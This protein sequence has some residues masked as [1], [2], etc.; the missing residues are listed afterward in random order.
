MKMN[1]KKWIGVLSIGAI[2]GGFVSAGIPITAEAVINAYTVKVKDEIYKYDKQELINDFLNFK[3]GDKSILYDDFA[4]KLKEGHGFY[5]F[6]DTEKGFV[7]Y[8]DISNA[9][10][11]TKE[12]NKSFDV[13]EFI[14]SKETKVIEVS[15]VKKAIVTKEGEVK[16]ETPLNDD[17]NHKENENKDKQDDDKSEDV[18]NKDSQSSEDKT[19]HHKNKHSHKSSS[20]VAQKDKEAVEKQKQEQAQKDK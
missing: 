6:Q 1:K 4:R 7:D 8:Y 14:K 10:L 20:D 13:E 12:E 9:F 15:W 19:S 18:V 5:A 3:C 16:Y 2:L 11:K 17:T